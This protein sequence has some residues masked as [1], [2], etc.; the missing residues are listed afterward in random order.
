MKLPLQRFISID[1]YSK[2]N[3]FHFTQ[4]FRISDVNS[5]TN[6]L[7]PHV[8]PGLFLSLHVTIFFLSPF[9]LIFFSDSVHGWPAGRPTIATQ[10]T[11]AALPCAQLQFICTHNK[12]RAPVAASRADELRLTL[13]PRQHWPGEE[14]EAD[15]A[16][17]RRS[18]PQ[19]FL[20]LELSVPGLTLMP[21]FSGWNPWASFYS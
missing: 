1:Y 9:R 8:R 17:L 7:G 12:A 6:R 18:K 14:G 16:P 13:T 2:G 3:Y 11:V 10:Q 4:N 21:T 20:Y 19:S 15:A 5:K